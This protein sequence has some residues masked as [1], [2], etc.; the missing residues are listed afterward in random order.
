MTRLRSEGWKEELS[1]NSKI[2]SKKS[3][4]SNLWKLL[5]FWTTIILFCGVSGCR[6]KTSGALLYIS[7]SKPFEFENNGLQKPSD[8]NVWIKDISS[9]EKK[10]VAKLSQGAMDPC[11]SSDGKLLVFSSNTQWPGAIYTVPTSGGKPDQLSDGETSVANPALSPNNKKIVYSGWDD[12]EKWNLHL[13]N[14]DGS[15]HIKLTDSDAIESFPAWYLHGSKIFFHKKEKD[16]SWHIYSVEPDGDNLTQLTQGSAMDWLPCASPDGK[17]IA[18]W[19]TRNSNHW[20]IFLMDVEGHNV[21]QISDGT[22]DWSVSSNVCQ[23]AWTPDSQKIIFCAPTE[24]MKSRLIELEI[25]TGRY[26]QISDKNENF[27]YSPVWINS[28]AKDELM[29]NGTLTVTPTSAS[30][31]KQP[32][33]TCSSDN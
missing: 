4:I 24:G 10:L 8:L 9:K 18:F 12:K 33:L 23:V 16:N 2:K 11:F 17:H 1:E 32:A 25:A 19:S 21:R 28:K 5:F 26:Q 6:E 22:G 20:E 13:M 30:I 14:F 27:C 7:V 3:L 15:R 29:K 31:T